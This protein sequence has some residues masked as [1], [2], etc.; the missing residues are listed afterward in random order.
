[1][2]YWEAIGLLAQ[3]LDMCEKLEASDLSFRYEGLCHARAEGHYATQV[4][5][6]LTGKPYDSVLADVTAAL[7]AQRAGKRGA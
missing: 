6:R 5:S 1:M 2:G 4:L 7:E 3:R